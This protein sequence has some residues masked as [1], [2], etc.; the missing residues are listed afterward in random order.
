[1]RSA[2][3]VEYCPVGDTKSPVGDTKKSLAHFSQLLP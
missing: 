1:L 2:R 3:S